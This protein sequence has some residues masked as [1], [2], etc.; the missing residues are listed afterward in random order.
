M[1]EAFSASKN[2]L[3]S[4]ACLV[5]PVEHTELSL[6]CN[7]CATHVGGTLQQCATPGVT[8]EPLGFFSKKLDKSQLIYSAFDR[9]LF[10]AY[11]AVNKHGS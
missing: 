5:H 9:E 7:A 8:W 11:T 10:A 2:T 3:D 4:S 6:F 1:R